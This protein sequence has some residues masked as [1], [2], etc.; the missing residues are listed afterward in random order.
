MKRVAILGSTGSIGSQALDVI[1]NNKQLLEVAVLSCAKSIDKLSDQ[2]D[3]YHPYA[4]VVAEEKDAAELQKKHPDC[5]I[6]WGD[7]G[8]CR[9]VRGENTR[10]GGTCDYG[11]RSAVRY[12]ADTC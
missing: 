7:D 2:I 5:E 6:F 10:R 9:A 1:D 12:K 3:R 11:C 8:L 4:A